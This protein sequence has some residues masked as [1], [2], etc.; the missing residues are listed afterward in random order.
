MQGLI[1]GCGAAEPEMKR[2]INTHNFPT[3]AAGQVQCE[4]QGL[5]LGF[6]VCLGLCRAS[7]AF[8]DSSGYL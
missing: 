7:P 5:P 6:K 1:S 2:V 8:L 4:V 3:S